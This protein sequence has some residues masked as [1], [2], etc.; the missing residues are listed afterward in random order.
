MYSSLQTERVRGGVNDEKAMTKAEAPSIGGSL[1]Y[2][3]RCRAALS[4]TSSFVVLFGGITTCHLMQ[5]VLGSAPVGEMHR[6]VYFAELGI[7]GFLTRYAVVQLA[8]PT[9][10]RREVVGSNPGNTSN[11]PFF[12]LSVIFRRAR[13]ESARKKTTTMKAGKAVG[14]LNPMHDNYRRRKEENHLSSDHWPP[15]KL[16]CYHRGAHGKNEM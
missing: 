11:T 7:S 2:T 5:T 13:C 8:I 16:G 10:S 6:N 9:P 3:Q 4:I 14:V 12:S 1:R 15:R